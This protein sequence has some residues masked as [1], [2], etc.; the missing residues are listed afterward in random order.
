MM[1]TFL[2]IIFWV[3]VCFVGYCIYRWVKAIKNSDL[4]D[5]WTWCLLINGSAVILNLINLFQKTIK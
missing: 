4:D 5:M 1:L 2:K 3:I